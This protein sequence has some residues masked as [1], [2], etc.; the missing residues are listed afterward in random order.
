[1]MAIFKREL[2][3]MYRTMVGPVFMAALLAFV[4]VLF[5]SINLIN[6]YPFFSAV[7]SNLSIILLLIVPVLTMR[8]FAEERRSKTDQLLLTSPVSVTRIVMGKYLAM[9]ALLGVCCVLMCAG[10]VIIHFY[11]SGSMTVDYLALLE[12][13][14]MAS[15]CIA[16]GMFVS[17]LTESQIIAAVGTFFI[18]L[19]LQLSEAISGVF[20]SSAIG[21]Y[22]LFFACIL[23]AA[24][25]VYYLTKN[26]IIGGGIG[27]A[28]LVALT[29]GFL[30]KKDAF[31]GSFA[32]AFNSLSLMNRFDD[33]LNQTLNLSVIIFYL[34]V[35]ALFVFLS[36]Q[37]IQKRRW[38]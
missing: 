4:G 8:S 3:S 15:A 1:M 22:V 2:R 38:S 6:G 11:G 34:T 17:T 5:V 18:L 36:V 37:S 23:L 14:L 24:L 26:F 16:I 27:V 33:I 25:L 30:L 7:L 29:A 12:F 10:P 20:P 9:V 13:F 31:A 32:K 19:V 35:C 21:S 28:G